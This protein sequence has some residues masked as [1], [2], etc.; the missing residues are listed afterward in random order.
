MPAS[1]GVEEIQLGLNK[2]K[3]KSENCSLENF[4]LLNFNINF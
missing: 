1:D 2:I 4:S 3:T